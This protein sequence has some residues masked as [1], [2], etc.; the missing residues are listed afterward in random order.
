MRNRQLPDYLS[1]RG[2][3]RLGL[4]LPAPLAA[5][6]WT[7]GLPLGWSAADTRQG[8]SCRPRPRVAMA[9]R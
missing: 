4:A 5:L 2:F 8:S 9:M 6:A 7:Q 1:R 3:L